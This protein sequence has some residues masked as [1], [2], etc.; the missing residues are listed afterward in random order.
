M[1]VIL[2][3]LVM[4]N[5]RD[6]SLNVPHMIDSIPLTGAQTPNVAEAEAAVVGVDPRKRS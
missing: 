4:V 6:Q 2:I 3:W 5:D 1:A